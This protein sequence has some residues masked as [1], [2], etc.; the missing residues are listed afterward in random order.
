MELEASEQKEAHTQELEAQEKKEKTLECL[1]NETDV[2]CTL[3]KARLVDPGRSFGWYIVLL[4]LFADC[5]R[6]YL[7]QSRYPKMDR[8]KRI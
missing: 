5:S 4:K 3:S 2:L 6:I 1:D 7:L 8:R